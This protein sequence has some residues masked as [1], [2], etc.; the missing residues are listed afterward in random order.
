MSTSTHL[1]IACLKPSFPENRH[2]NES[3]HVNGGN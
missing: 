2:V 1:S 3:C